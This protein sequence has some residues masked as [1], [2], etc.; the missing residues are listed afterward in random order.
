MQ[1]SQH[2]GPCKLFFRCDIPWYISK[3]KG[4]QDATHCKAVS[5]FRFQGSEVFIRKDL[6]SGDV[7]LSPRPESW[8]GFFQLVEQAHVPQD[9]MSDRG[10]STPQKR[11]LF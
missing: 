4:Q 10:D 8:D 2:D 3:A 9:F 11:D 5:D 1:I 6:T 7:I